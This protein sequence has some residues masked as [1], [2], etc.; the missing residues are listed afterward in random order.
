MAGRWSNWSKA[1][2]EEVLIDGLVGDFDEAVFGQLLRVEGRG[3][4]EVGEVEDL[5]TWPGCAEYHVEIILQG[6]KIKHWQVSAEMGQN[7]KRVKGRSLRKRER[8]VEGVREL[9]M[10]EKD[11]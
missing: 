2:F 7:E 4:G 9:K 5:G 8:R 3:F 6:K 11:T 10:M 1:Y